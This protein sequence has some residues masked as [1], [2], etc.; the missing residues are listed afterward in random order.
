MK[1]TVLKYQVVIKKEGKNYIA[2]VPTLAISDFGKS[3][4]D[5]MK[6]VQEAIECHI[7]GL[8]KTGSE[9]PLPDSDEY[10]ISQA[11]VKAPANIKLAY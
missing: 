1:I 7:E 5:A 3:V 6:H 4:N 10:Y 9:I 8:A 11:H 2:Y